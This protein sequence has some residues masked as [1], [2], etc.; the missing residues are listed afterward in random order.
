MREGDLYRERV[1]MTYVP[2]L[3]QEGS[4]YI[5][6]DEVGSKEI[7]YHIIVLTIAANG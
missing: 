3:P 2:S 4:V 6:D 5:E 1:R 7:N